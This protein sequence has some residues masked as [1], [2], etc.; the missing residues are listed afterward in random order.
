MLLHSRNN[1]TETVRHKKGEI[2]DRNPWHPPILAWFG[3][4]VLKMTFTSLSEDTFSVRC[5]YWGILE[6]F[7]SS[8]FILQFLPH[9]LRRPNSCEQAPRIWSSSSTPTP[10]WGTDLSSG[11]RS[12]IAP[13]NP[14]GRRLTAWGHSP[15][16]SGIWSRTQS[17]GS[18]SYSPDPGRAA[19]GLLDLLWSAG[20]SVQV[21]WF[22]H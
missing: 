4:F 1:I 22:R 6:K 12:S 2:S 10:S 3:T 14:C 8:L 9:L 13:A 21:S 18:V 7:D 20:Q 16:K 11:G 19:R 15:T 17:T 5:C